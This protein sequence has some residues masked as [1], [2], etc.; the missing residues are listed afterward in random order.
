MKGVERLV[1]D[2][3]VPGLVVP[4][5]TVTG[6][7]VAADLRFERLE[8]GSLFVSQWSGG[9][10]VGSRLLEVAEVAALCALCA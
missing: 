1:A 6:S 3:D 7:L 4:S 8:D 5:A 10:M 9:M 2:P